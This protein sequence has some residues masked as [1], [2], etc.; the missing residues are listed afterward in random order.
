MSFKC[1]HISDIHF[2]G[3]TRHDEYRRS[4]NSFFKKIKTLNPDA[5]FIGGDIVHSK[6]QGISPELID[7]LIWWFKSMA[8]IAP[9]HVILGNHDGLI[10]NKDRQDAISPIINA[11][12]PDENRIR[13]YKKSGTYPVGIPGY[14]WCIFSCFDTEGWD[15][16]KPVPGDINIA[17][18]HG[19]VEGSLTDINWN[20]EG[21]VH[22]D[23][24]ENFD[25]AF[26]GDIHKL[27]YLN[28][29]KTIAYPG[30]SIQQNYGE[31]PGKGFLFWEI[32]SASQFKS[33]FYEIEHDMPFVTIDWAGSVQSTLDAAESAPDGAR[34]R[35]RAD[36]IISQA[37][38][39]QLHSALK[40]FKDASEIVYKN[41]YDSSALTSNSSGFLSE[42]LR[43]S[44][45]HHKLMREYYKDVSLTDDEW[46]AIDELLTRYLSV[47]SH[48]DSSRNN[49]WSIK[50]VNF[51]NLFCYGKGNLIN[52]DKMSGITGLFG[53]NRAGKSSIPG[54]VM[55]GL[56]N[57][58][59]RGPIK[60][61]HIINSRKGYCSSSLDIAVNGRLYRIERQSTK[62]ETRAGKLHAVTHLNFFMID[63]EGNSIKDLSGEQRRETEKHVRSL[64]GTADDFLLTSL[65]SQGEMNSFIKHK[66]TQRKSILTNF[67]DLN[68]FEDMFLAAKEDSAAINASIKKAPD[69][70]WDTII[71]EKTLERD[72]KIND[73]IEVDQSLAALRKEHQE[74]KIILAT[75][76]DK[77][78]V[79]QADVQLQEKKV[80][81]LRGNISSMGNKAV[82]M[83]AA[84]EANA[85]TLKKIKSM[86]DLF[87]IE[88][89]R[90]RLQAQAGLER[91][92]VHLEHEHTKAKSV[93]QNQK[94]SVSK[95]NDVPCG[96]KFLT[97]KFIKESHKNKKLLP[98]Q[99]EIVENLLSEVRAAKKSLK[100]L[101]GEN[102]QEKLQKYDSFL[103]QETDLTVR[104]SRETMELHSIETNL[105]TLS[106][107][108]EENSRLLED[109]RLRVSDSAESG[110]VSKLKGTIH[111][112]ES[113]ISSTDLN[114][115]SL[116]ES[117]GLLSSEIE[118][119]HN[120][121]DE[122]KELMS[123]WRVYDLFMSAV[124]KKG[125]PLNIISSQLPAINAEIS[126][127]LQDVVGF[128]VEL[129]TDNNSNA[130][131]IY[132]NYGDS[133]R[134]IECASGMEK[135]MASLAIRVALI[136][137]SSLPKTDLLIIDEGF[138]ALDDMN[139]EACNRLL[140]SLK[141]WFKNI[142][143]I[144]HV[145]AVKDIVDNVVDITKKGKDSKIFCNGNEVS[146][147]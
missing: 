114:R 35:V 4:F 77:D 75:H 2:R 84:V 15:D 91:S 69:R 129:E 102:L 55:Y 64:V 136:N 18:F 144:S 44:R 109:M 116:S 45:A 76:K 57:T 130:M 112:I 26:L 95:L 20:I 147:A 94:K 22:V 43:D 17:A 118:N 131:D 49:K 30:S 89:L 34:F 41:D 80:N 137:V 127:I 73:R 134:I 124:S 21:E 100:V 54:A 96:D 10:L 63:E 78:L 86:K 117:I 40:E 81:E 99:N 7:I 19:G 110:A 113:S 14:N 126:K 115:M 1:V 101:Q 13:L 106:D 9:V 132:I 111:D 38:I 142:L 36:Q 53:P 3:L 59:D 71:L 79:T 120:E 103:K 104:I 141:R 88:E 32:E 5:I 72:R 70:E 105:K 87:P 107:S 83:S 16:V 74:L 121:R 56:Y 27:Q 65:A 146:D 24:F 23:F 145:D 28:E 125:I 37:E 92:L 123:K 133:R 6:T 50:K 68:V 138:G 33:T 139:V 61:L 12:D 140:K 108:L 85:D 11:I 67:L 39:K 46:G 119:L 66:A 48:N 25:F 51:D 90:D 93:L 135:M 8:D 143:V 58:T 122:Y 47:I 60:N 97:C 42:D 52:F 62:H 128:T 31:D 29:K 82:T 98:N